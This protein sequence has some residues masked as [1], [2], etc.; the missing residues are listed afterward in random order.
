MA[1]SARLCWSTLCWKKALPKKPAS[2]GAVL[3]KKNSSAGGSMG[4]S[5]AGAG[6]SGLGRREAD[7][8]GSCL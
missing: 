5:I 8:G 2:W 7:L 4:S 6:A 1:G 3:I